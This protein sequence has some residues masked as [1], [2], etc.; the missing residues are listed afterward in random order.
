ML[1]ARAATAAAARARAN[2]LG[3]ALC[4]SPRRPSSSSSAAASVSLFKPSLGL[5]I[6]GKE[7]AASS[8]RSIPVENPSTEETLFTIEEADATD[9]HAA[10]LSSQAS[11]QSG[12]WSKAD[13]SE[14]YA[15]LNRIAQALRDRTEEFAERDA[16]QTGRPIREM[17]TQLGRLPE[18]LEYFAAVARTHNGY[19]PPYKGDMVNYVKRVPLGVVAQI[20][21]WNHPLLIA[22]KKIAPALAAGNSIVVK[23]SEQAPASVVEFARLCKHAGLPDGV[24]N[25]VCGYGGIAGKALSESPLIKKVDLTGGNV[26]GAAVGSSAGRN[27][28]P[29]IAELGGKSPL[30]CFNDADLDAVVNGAAFASFIASGQTCVTA[31]RFIVQSGIHDEFV[32]RLVAK[33][34]QLK[35]GLPLDPTSQI[36]PVISA[37]QLAKIEGL[38]ANAVR[39]GAQVAIG[40]KRASKDLFAKGHYFEPTVLVGCHPD[41]EIAQEEVFGPV[42]VVIKAESEQEAVEFANRSRYGLAASVWTTD[43]KRAHRVA[44]KLDVGIVWINGH[45]HN[46]PSSPWGGMKES[47]IGRENSIEAFEEYTQSKSVVVNYGPATDWFA[48]GNVR[49]G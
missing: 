9:V 13:V 7:V 42:V 6:D 35:L 32:S 14:R 20:T 12:V 47:G 30:V 36:G 18:W 21:P 43:V 5:W 40:G 10:I 1:S 27:L 46:D 11:F 26:A 49:Y 34:K 15:V 4:C 8:G 23:P 19:V 39:D 2:L 45:H 16:L 31:S 41:A 48:G 17:K 33:T 44:D 25:V 28:V 38:V 3:P 29:M 22:V 37:G 24:L